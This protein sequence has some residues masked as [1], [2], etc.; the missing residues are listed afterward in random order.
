MKCIANLLAFSMK[1]EMR[2]KFTSVTIKP[3]TGQ[4]E[5]KSRQAVTVVGPDLATCLFII[6]QNS[7]RFVGR[8]RMFASCRLS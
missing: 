1:N 5:T 2:C 4:A 8:E 6:C 3:H 7:C